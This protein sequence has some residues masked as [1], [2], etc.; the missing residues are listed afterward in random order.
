[1]ALRFAG[2]LLGVNQDERTFN[3]KSNEVSEN[4]GGEAEGVVNFGN[5]LT[6]KAKFEVTGNKKTLCQTL[7]VRGGNRIEPPLEE[8]NRTSNC[9]DRLGNIGDQHRTEEIIAEY[10]RRTEKSI[11]FWSVTARGKDRGLRYEA[12]RYGLVDDFPFSNIGCRRGR[13]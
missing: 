6:G 7:L 11:W 10:R 9:Q 3:V 1:M 12:V 5:K 13:T 2:K 4:E 8:R